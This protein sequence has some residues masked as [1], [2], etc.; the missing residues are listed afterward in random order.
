[1][2]GLGAAASVFAAVQVADQIAER[3]KQLYEFWSVVNEAPENIQA[4]ASDLRLL[5]SVIVQISNNCQNLAQGKNSG[6]D[7]LTVDVLKACKLLYIMIVMYQRVVN[8]VLFRH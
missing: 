5:S 1:M 8:D 7:S 6:F 4:I 3:I 2:E